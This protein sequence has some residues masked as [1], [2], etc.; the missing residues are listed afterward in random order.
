MNIDQGKV[1]SSSP[2]EQHKPAQPI[3][4]NVENQAPATTQVE[5]QAPATTQVE[6]QAP[7][8][9]QVEN[10]APAATGQITLDQ[11]QLNTLIQNA[12]TA[13]LNSQKAT[14]EAA[15][16]EEAERV[17]N[18]FDRQVERFYK[19]TI[20]NKVDTNGID[21]D[22]PDIQEKLNNMLYDDTKIK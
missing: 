18:S 9:T 21:F 5:N 22:D 7:A 6:N 20:E 16:K 11:N 15:A 3:A 4:N 13:A 12:V 8:A 10:Q 17:F 2:Y 14:K 19:A 1:P